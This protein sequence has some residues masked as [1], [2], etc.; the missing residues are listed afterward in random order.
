M[1]KADF[2]SLGL[3]SSAVMIWLVWVNCVFFCLLQAKL[4]TKFWEHKVS[5]ATP[6][7]HLEEA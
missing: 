6:P 3:Q 2:P 1:R 7:S 4:E 5:R